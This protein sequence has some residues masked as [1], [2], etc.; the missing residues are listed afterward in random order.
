MRKRI[1]EV[2]EDYNFLMGYTVGKK[3]EWWYGIEGIYFIYMGDWNDPL[4]GYEGWTFNIHEVED[5]MWEW[6]QEYQQEYGIPE[7]DDEDYDE[8]EAFARYMKESAC[9]V[10]ELLD[11]IIDQE[12]LEIK[13]VAA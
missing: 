10:Y 3:Q 8:R 9:A 6:F 5:C 1:E 2:R 13:E 7:G 12:G 4:I 11:M